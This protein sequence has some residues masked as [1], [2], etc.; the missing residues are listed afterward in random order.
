MSKQA[1]LLKEIVKTREL[2]SVELRKAMK[3]EIP[4][5]EK[6]FSL[7]KRYGELDAEMSYYE[8]STFANIYKSLNSVQKQKL[9]Q[10]RNQSVL[11]T[12]VYLYS[13]PIDLPL[14][15]AN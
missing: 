9:I 2:V 10:I 8:A 4:D 7:I 12:G 5:K 6:V 1:P 13:D 11:P 15:L 14:N 3:N